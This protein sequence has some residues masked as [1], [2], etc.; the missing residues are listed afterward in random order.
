MYDLDASGRYLVSPYGIYRL[1]D[2]PV[3]S[4]AE[5]VDVLVAYVPL[6]ARTDSQRFTAFRR[7][8]DGWLCVDGGWSREFEAR[9]TAAGVTASRPVTRPAL[10]DLLALAFVDGSEGSEAA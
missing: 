1:L 7:A 2:L 10:L 3:W 6:D 4:S 9:R 5:Q 8:E